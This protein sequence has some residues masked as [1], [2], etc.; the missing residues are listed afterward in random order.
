MT[1]SGSPTRGWS[2]WPPPRAAARLFGRPAGDD[3]AAGLFPFR[4]ARRVSPLP[5]RTSRCQ[6]VGGDAGI[7]LPGGVAERAARPGADRATPSRRAHAWN[8]WSRWMRSARPTAIRCWRARRSSCAISRTGLC[9]PV[10]QRSLPLADRRGFRG[11]GRGAA[12]HCR[13]AVSRVGL[14]LRAPGAGRGHRQS[15]DGA[16]LHRQWPASAAADALVPVQ[17]EC[18][19]PNTGRRARWSTPLP[20]RCA[21]RLARWRA[22]WW[23]GQGAAAIRSEATMKRMPVGI[24]LLPYS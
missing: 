14:R 6:P 16:R 12:L 2:G 8:C 9:Q 15:A 24:L 18:G 13:D 1:R 23:P 5:C 4:A 10:G 21:S 19:I 7:A 22:G 11:R 20:R 3:R 17:G